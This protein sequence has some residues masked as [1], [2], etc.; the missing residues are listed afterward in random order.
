V[1]FEIDLSPENSAALCL[2]P[3]HDRRSTPQ[4]PISVLLSVTDKNAS[5]IFDRSGIFSHFLS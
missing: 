4:L 1:Y 5:D 2:I 3:S